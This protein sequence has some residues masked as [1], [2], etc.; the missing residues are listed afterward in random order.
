MRFRRRRFS[1]LVSLS[2][3]LPVGPNVCVFLYES[4]CVRS[5]NWFGVVQFCT[6]EGFITAI[7][8]EWPRLFRRRKE[9][10]VLVTCLLSYIVGLSMVT[11]V[12]AV[13]RAPTPVDFRQQQ[14]PG[15]AAQESEPLIWYCHLLWNAVIIFVMFPWQGEFPIPRKLLH[16]WQSSRI[17]ALRNLKN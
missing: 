13:Q 4:H 12:C 6:L 11:Q 15:S 1:I 2:G 9:L 5:I 17:N 3:F 7:V 16:F 8:D 14:V 10:V